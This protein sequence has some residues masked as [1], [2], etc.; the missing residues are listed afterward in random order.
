MRVD[1][2]FIVS[3]RRSSSSS[4]ASVASVALEAYES[5]NELFELIP[6]LGFFALL[7]PI[8]LEF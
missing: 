1:T 5:S 4:V 6:M 2:E 8:I 7:P 3:N